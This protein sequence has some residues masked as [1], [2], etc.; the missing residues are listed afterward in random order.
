[1][2]FNHL[3]TRR[4][5]HHR[6]NPILETP[7]RIG[8][9]ARSE[10]RA[11]LVAWRGHS[12]WQSLPWP[13]TEAPGGHNP[14]FSTDQHGRKTPTDSV[15]YYAFPEREN[16]SAAT[17]AASESRAPARPF[18]RHWPCTISGSRSR[19]P[20]AP[21]ASESGRRLFTVGGNFNGVNKNGIFSRDRPKPGT[22]ANGHRLLRKLCRSWCAVSHQV[23]CRKSFSAQAVIFYVEHVSA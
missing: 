18:G 20:C 22:I 16:S 4:C 6:E 2:R 17:A 8:H 5:L 19:S 15:V 9:G 14:P 12:R 1:L 13:G 23:G 11:S 10:P 3:G 7:Q 21:F